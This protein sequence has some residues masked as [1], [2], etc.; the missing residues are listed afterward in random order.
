MVYY[1]GRLQYEN[2]FMFL[3]LLFLCTINADL[4]SDRIVNAKFWI[5]RSHSAEDMLI[6]YS[7]SV[8]T[9]DI[10][11]EVQTLGAFC[12][13]VVAMEYDSVVLA[14]EILGGIAPVKVWTLWDQSTTK[15]VT[16]NILEADF[17]MNVTTAYDF[18]LQDYLVKNQS[19]RL[20]EY[21]TFQ[22]NS[23]L[24][25]MGYT[26]HDSAA[27]KAFALVDAIL[28]HSILCGGIIFPACNVSNGAGGT[29]L[30]DTG[31][32]SVEDCITF[33]DNLETQ[34]HPC[35]DAQKS[36]TDSCRD[37]HGISSFILPQIHCQHVRPVSAVCFDSC[38]PACSNCHSNA[39]CIA[40]HPGI[41]TN[42]SV[43]YKCQCNPGF[44][45]NGTSC[46]PL[47]CL[48]GQ[49][50]GLYGSYEC[51]TGLCKCTETFEYHPEGYGTN[52]LCVCPNGGQIIYNNS[53]PICVPVGKCV[54]GQYE[55]N[56]QAYNQVKCSVFGTNQFSPF[57]D[58]ICNYGF[59][60]GWEYPCFCDTTTRRVL[61]SSSFNAELCLGITECTNDWHCTYP[62]TCH[63]SGQQIGTCA[64]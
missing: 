60:G 44:V 49:C 63:L 8:V 48:Y 23:A 56:I 11:H 38:L 37:L 57:R 6:G 40:T 25:T 46:Q 4:T 55:C 59:K 51:S 20:R 54:Q 26:I 18:V 15:W 19:F 32:T 62:Q 9:A 17:E 10:C 2:Y 16:T 61:W 14:V 52:G 33:M 30:P 35:P 50:P 5:D 1:S 3:I 13:R 34:N 64:A 27:N 47:A 7:T 22:P 29:Y 12:G 39:E 21:I 41:P 58:C 42:F 31:Y 45:G 43:V 36:N 24:I 28:P 53:Q